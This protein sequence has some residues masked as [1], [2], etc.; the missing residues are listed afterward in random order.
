MVKVYKAVHMRLVEVM[1]EMVEQKVNPTN[2]H[3]PMAH[4]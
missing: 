3:Q 2:H 4:L 1:E